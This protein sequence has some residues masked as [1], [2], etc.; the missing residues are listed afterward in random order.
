MSDL[1]TVT[2]LLA[3]ARAYGLSGVSF[4]EAVPLEQVARDYNGIGPSWFPD[5][6]RRA[7]D[8]LSPDLCCCALIHDVR[9]AH[10]PGTV[11]AFNASNAE[12]E[13]NGLIVARTRYGWYDPRRYILKHKARAFADLCQAFG[14]SAYVAANVNKMI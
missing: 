7:I 3:Q 9:W 8:R 12:L 10:N 2:R 11:A 4:V 13:A 6:L 1:P 5:V 14:W